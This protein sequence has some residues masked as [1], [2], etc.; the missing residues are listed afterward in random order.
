MNENVLYIGLGSFGFAAYEISDPKNPRHLAT[1]R[2]FDGEA[3]LPFAAGALS[4]CIVPDDPTLIYIGNA[5]ERG[6]DEV[7]GYKL[8]IQ[9]PTVEVVVPE[10]SFTPMDT[11]E[12]PAVIGLTPDTVAQSSNYFGR[13]GDTDSTSDLNGDNTST[14]EAYGDDDDDDDDDF[15]TLIV[16]TGSDGT[17]SSSSSSPSHVFIVNVVKTPL[18]HI[19]GGNPS[20]P[21]PPSP[22]L[23]TIQ[24]SSSFSSGAWLLPT[25]VSVAVAA[26]VAVMC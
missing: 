23:P 9:P 25:M 26:A 19:L 8:D 5:D 10:T 13:S 11:P 16:G 17:S 18:S 2:T 24:R 15:A 3:G 4:A 1:K 6:R 21:T 20:A 12:V 14:T 7:L 22:H